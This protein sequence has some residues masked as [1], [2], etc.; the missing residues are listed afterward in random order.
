M[1]KRI[2]EIAERIHKLNVWEKAAKNQF[3]IELKGEAAPYFVIADPVYEHPMLRAHILFLEGWQGFQTYSLW[4]QDKSYGF[5]TTPMELLGIEVLWLKK[6]GLMVMRNRPGC[7]PIINDPVYVKK[8][9]KLLWQVYGLFLRLEENEN[10]SMKYVNDGSMLAMREVTAKRFEEVALKVLPIIPHKESVSYPVAMAKKAKDLGV[11]DGETWVVSFGPNID[12]VT[13][14]ELHRFAYQL[15]IDRK[16]D[17]VNLLT[18]SCSVNPP[19]ITLRDL[20]ESY[21]PRVL[22]AIIELGYMPGEIEV[23]NKRDF[24]L[25]RSLTLELPFKLHLITPP[26]GKNPAT[27]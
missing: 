6:G 8:T 20:Y 23:H 15:T 4:R 12:C 10:L 7:Q 22:R 27:E 11:K 16:E 1:D 2:L 19:T 14:D 21:P 9:E 24:R 17:K 18:A 13:R 5:I 3:A 25:L 26:T